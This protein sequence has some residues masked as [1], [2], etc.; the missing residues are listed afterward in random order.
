MKTRLKELRVE[1][2]YTQQEVANAIMCA[3]STYAHYEKDERRIDPDTLI[4]LSKFFK[5]SIDYILY[6]DVV[7]EMNG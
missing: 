3:V 7:G 6:N 2:G 4:N 5:V 1:K